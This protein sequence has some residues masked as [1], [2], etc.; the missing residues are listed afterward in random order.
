MSWEAGVRYEMTDIR[1]DDLDA[2]ESVKNDY[3]MLLPSASAK[4][5]ITA[6][7]RISASVARTNRRPRFDYISPALLEE[8]FA[9]NDLLGN[10]DLK[11]ETAWGVDLG[12]E[13]RLGRTGVAGVNVFYRK[14]SDLVEIASTGL[15]GSEG[16]G[17]LILQPRNAGKGKAWGIEFD[18]S[19][20][21][22]I[23]GLRETGIFGN[24]S[25]LDSKIR[26]F[27]GSRR[28]NGQSRYV[29]NAGVIQNLPS[30]GAAMGVTYR[31]QGSA[32][33]RIVGEEIRTTYGADLEVFVEKRLFGK[34]TVRGVASNLLNG[35]K[36]ETFNKFDSI[37]DQLGRHFDEYELESEEAGPVF[38]LIARMVF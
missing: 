21:L 9:D 18:L 34:M 10:P 6:N 7:D 17:T 22:G 1:V 12:Y 2:D 28:F 31:K 38:Q 25:L 35:K 4:I 5:A 36:R 16:E 23:I 11:P 29:Y 8:E 37:D 19:A 27:A 3:A 24:L 32:V 33:D 13:R 26:D 30:L 14:V 15:E 20:S